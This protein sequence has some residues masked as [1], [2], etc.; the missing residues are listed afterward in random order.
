[1]HLPPLLVF[2]EQFSEDPYFA[3]FEQ[4]TPLQPKK[5]PFQ[6]H[7]FPAIS[8][9]YKISVFP[10]WLF[11]PM[12]TTI[13]ENTVQSKKGLICNINIAYFFFLSDSP[14]NLFEVHLLPIC[15]LLH[16]LYSLLL[17]LLV[18]LFALLNKLLYVCINSTRHATHK[19][20]V[21][22]RV[23]CFYAFTIFKESAF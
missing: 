16:P 7:F 10:D 8:L 6:D 11:R 20:S 15:P 14:L 1:M 5:Q 18:L 12:C 22:G 9:G 3:V 17:I 13:P 2:H 4:N 21:P 23:F 19:N